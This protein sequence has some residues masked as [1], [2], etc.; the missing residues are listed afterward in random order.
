MVLD[1][2]FSIANGYKMDKLRP[3]TVTAW[4]FEKVLP[5]FI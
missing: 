3:G 4:R 1:R 2:L 5:A